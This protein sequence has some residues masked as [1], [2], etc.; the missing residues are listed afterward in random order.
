MNETY[1]L[2]QQRATFL[3]SIRNDLVLK[4]QDKREM[5]F[6]Q[7]G[8]GRK[9]FKQHWNNKGLRVIVNLLLPI[10]MIIMDIYLPARD[11]LKLIFYKKK[12]LLSER[13]FVGYS[14]RLFT[15]TKQAGLQCEGDFWMRLKSNEYILPERK[16]TVTIYDFVSV[17][18]ILKSSF[19]SFFLH[20]QIIIIFGY[21]KY[22][23][24]YNAY[25]W[26][27]TDFALRHVPDNVELFYCFICDRNAILIDRLPH[28][29]KCMIQHGTMHFGNSDGH[30]PYLE[31]H[32]EKGFYI[33]KS[34]YKSSPSTVYCYTDDDEW[35][36]S[37]SVIANHPLFV[38]IGYGFKPSYKSKKKSVL[39]IGNYYMNAEKEDYLLSELQKL[40][41]EVYLKNHPAIDNSLYTTFKNK[42]VFS[43]IEGVETKLPDAD[44]VISYDSTLAYEYASIGTKVLYYGHFDINK[45]QDIVS[46]ELSL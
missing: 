34:L 23:L 18:D 37:N 3:L 42:Y 41:I 5:S 10:I 32:E 40:D 29:R 17:I 20:L 36:L 35:A 22:F 12:T 39:I 6:E 33:W 19:Q 7:I 30:N 31:Y 1:S 9:V 2:K 15:I 16:P 24:S 26:C 21:D 28:K 45:I 11:I 43:F 27:V 13:L 46:N 44:L 25:E 8:A 4:A 14:R 38:K